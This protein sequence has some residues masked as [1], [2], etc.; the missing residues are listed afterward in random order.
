MK[1]PDNEIYIDNEL[2]RCPLCNKKLTKYD[3]GYLCQNENG[4][5]ASFDINMEYIE[6]L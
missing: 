6:T 1:I 2:I 4:C 3:D 5:G